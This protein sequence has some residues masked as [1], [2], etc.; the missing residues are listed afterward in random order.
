MKKV[1][2]ATL[3]LFSTLTTFSQ[4]SGLVFNPLYKPFYHGV[5]S[6]DPLHNRV[7]IWTRVTPDAGFVGTANVDWRVALDTGMVN[8]VQ[9]GT[10]GTD[11]SKDY[12]VKVDVT[13]LTPNTYYYYEFTFNNMH[14][15]RG[16]TR[17]APL[18]MQDSLRFGIV[19]CS[20]YEA[21]FFNVYRVLKERNDVDA[22]IHLGDYI[23]EYEH[24]GYAYNS[25]V[26]R[27]FEPTSEIIALSDYRARYSCYK[28]DE[29]LLRLH[30]Q[31]PFIIVWDDHESAN[32]SW[33]NGAEN[34]SAAEGSWVD[35]K[36]ASQ[37]AFMEWLP[38]RPK[39][40]G[41]FTEIYRKIQFGPLMDLLM[42]DTRLIGRE[43]QAGTTGSTVNNQN[44]TLL[45]ST[46]FNWLISNLAVTNSQWKIIGQQV[47]MAPLKIAGV[48]VNGDQWDGYPAERTKII[49]QVLTND[50]K[51]L[52]VL[53]GDIH[54]SWANDIPTANY[55]SNGNG[56]AFVEMVTPAVTSP[57]F[58][59]NVGSTII[60][61]ANNH[62]KWVDLSAR[63]FIILS[64]SQLRAQGDWFF[65]NT[66]NS[67]SGAHSHASS[68]Y[69]N[70][71]ERNLRNS[72]S[73]ML[74][75][76]DMDKTPAP[77]WQR[78]FVLPVDTTTPPDTTVIDT[79]ISIIQHQMAVLGVYPNPF[80]TGIS[81]QIYV[82]EDMDLQMSLFD[83]QGKQVAIKE[84]AQ[85]AHGLHFLTM[86]MGAIPN[87]V[88]IL[89]IRTKYG[90]K[91]V[92]LVKE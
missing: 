27:T 82:P 46:Q 45:G 9:Y 60:R 85:Q 79:N 42:L 69:V 81:V 55:Q 17:T 87:A 62:I 31:Y 10:V 72:S 65:V 32:D 34:H 15:I 6:G 73:I 41:N 43:E 22:I 30:Q 23:Y 49:S 71:N 4:N 78:T 26:G 24:N 16:R 84:F 80:S 8:I 53:T 77:E 14:S 11:Q 1:I 89:N 57:A 91:S 61:A 70:A 3:I 39:T 76:Y 54:C 21:G 48:G 18:A 51:N 40:Q 12:T 29:D 68:W 56:S 83:L 63:G 47:M 25:T 64:V 92:K 50:F 5:A 44:R 67:R 20:N 37:Q 19:S 28:L 58:P 35:R 74:P 59:I 52:V 66:I 2:L 7:I 88:Y 13:G 38:V 86:E 90:I 75:R 33:M 36:T